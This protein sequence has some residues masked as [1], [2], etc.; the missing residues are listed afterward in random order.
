MALRERSE[1]YFLKAPV[2]NVRNWMLRVE[3]GL[4]DAEQSRSKK[5]EDIRN[6]FVPLPFCS[7]L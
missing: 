5:Q 7:T 1:E 6:F 4:L 3:Y 2:R